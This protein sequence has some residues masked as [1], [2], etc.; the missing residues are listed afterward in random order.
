M[1][2]VLENLSLIWARTWSHLALAVPAI[3]LS[4]LVSVP[5]GWVAHRYRWSRLAL[6]TGAGLMYAIPSLPLFIV[7]PTIIGVG[8][9]DALNVIV[10]LTLY[11]MALMVRSAADALA[12]VGEAVRLSATALGYSSARQFWE[13]DLPL[14]GPVLLAGLRVVAVSTIS[15][16]TVSGLL[17]VPNLGL[18]FTDGFQ[19]GLIAEVVTG[20][21]ATV[22]LALLV[23]GVLVLGGRAV[24]PWAKAVRTT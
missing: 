8:V 3:A 21:V 15:L 9:R 14:A 22:V 1:T 12:S 24:M 11:G 4:F 6:L 10:A 7:L 13:V 23:D 5:L 17:G 2:W 16:V 20:I 18:L 19:R